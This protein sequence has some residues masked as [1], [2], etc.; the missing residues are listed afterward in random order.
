M[1]AISLLQT[2]PPTGPST[3]N[4]EQRAE[5]TQPL[6]L[7]RDASGGAR[8]QFFLRLGRSTA[9]LPDFARQTIDPMSQLRQRQ[10]ALSS[11]L[12]LRVF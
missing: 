5:L 8:G 12:N 3:V 4:G 7:L 6:T 2:R 10:W 1:L 11:G 9:R